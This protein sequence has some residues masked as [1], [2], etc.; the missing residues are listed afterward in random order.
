MKKI[1][2]ISMML[3][4][5]VMINMGAIQ[6]QKYGY[7]SSEALLLQLP[8]VKQADAN[9][10]A[11]M[12]QFQKK[13]KSM[14][15]ALQAKEDEAIQKKERGELSPAQEQALLKELQQE[16][17]EIQKFEK[18]AAEKMQQKRIE[19]LGPVQEK[20]QNAIND[21]AKENG[22]TMILEA[23][24]LLFAEESADVSALVKAKLG[25]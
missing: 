13:G 25:I 16:G 6:A 3:I 8:E 19:L 12:T 23:G 18:E 15:E 7:V 5:F 24:V 10:Q 14:V 4:A 22:Y 17:T 2:K 1:I 20:I 21:V 9:L 11:M